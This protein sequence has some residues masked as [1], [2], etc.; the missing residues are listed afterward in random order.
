MM[1]YSIL[2]LCPRTP[3]PIKLQ[4]IPILN[5]YSFQKFLDDLESTGGSSMDFSM[6]REL[7]LL[8]RDEVDNKRQTLTKTSEFN[9]INHVVNPDMLRKGGNPINT[10][11]CDLTLNKSKSK[12]DTLINENDAHLLVRDIS[13]DNVQDFSFSGF[14]SNISTSLQH[15][16]RKDNGH[17]Y[18]P[19][20]RRSTRTK[21]KTERFQIGF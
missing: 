9:V 21:R 17:H 16:W 7:F 10:E 2:E 18:V 4:D 6:S 1:D 3:S 19:N 5:S 11:D 20:I 15:L 8:S 13:H 14:E 12:E